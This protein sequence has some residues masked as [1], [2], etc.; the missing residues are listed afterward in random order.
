MNLRDVRWA[1]SAFRAGTTRQARLYYL[2]RSPRYRDPHRFSHVWQRRASVPPGHGRRVPPAPGAPGRT[3]RRRR[4]P[5][6]RP[7]IVGTG[8]EGSAGPARTTPQR[9]LRVHLSEPRSE[10]G[11]ASPRLQLPLRAAQP[12]RAIP[13]IHHTHAHTAVPSPRSTTHSPVR[14]ALAISGLPAPVQAGASRVSCLSAGPSRRAGTPRPTAPSHRAAP[15]VKGTGSGSHA[16]WGRA[17]AARA[18]AARNRPGESWARGSTTTARPQGP[19]PE[20]D[21]RWTRGETTRFWRRRCSQRKPSRPE[22]HPTVPPGV[23]GAAPGLHGAPQRREQWRESSPPAPPCA[24]RPRCTAPGA[25][26]ARG[27]SLMQRCPRGSCQ[28]P[29]GRASACCPALRWCRGWTAAMHCLVS[30][31][32]A[33]RAEL[34]NFQGIT[35]FLS[36][37]DRRWRHFS[38]A[39]DGKTEQPAPPSP[40]RIGRN[41]V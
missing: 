33:A 35:W 15:A 25:H 26:R 18:A 23:Q 31:R 30:Q 4:S 17:Q 41:S 5:T 40:L 12:R 20:P 10:R 13:A 8:T 22:A 7:A 9:I 3:P 38:N 24:E 16:P 37:R 11:C 34:G 29:G 14:R 39:S 36:L 21:C 19:P 27:S 2:P 32:S 28:Q 6:Q 1:A